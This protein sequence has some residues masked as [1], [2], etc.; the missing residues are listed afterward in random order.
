MEAVLVYRIG[1]C[2]YLDKNS[3]CLTSK[4]DRCL[5]ELQVERLEVKLAFATCK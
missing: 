2:L 1:D 4:G 5:L 3:R